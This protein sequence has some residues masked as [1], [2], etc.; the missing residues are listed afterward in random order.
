MKGFGILIPILSV[1]AFAAACGTATTTITGK[2]GTTITTPASVAGTYTLNF[3]KNGTGTVEVNGQPTG[4]TFTFKGS[5]LT[6]PGG[7]EN[8]CPKSGT[9]RIHL[10]GKRLTL[11]AIHDTCT[12]G[13]AQVFPG[14]IW[15]KVG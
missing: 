9:Y 6:S 12:I 7:G 4:H 3:K 10:A 1:L 15:T 8:V 11:K 2:Y 13:R 14:H 5:T